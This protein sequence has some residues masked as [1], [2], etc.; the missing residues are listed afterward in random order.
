MIVKNESKF[1]RRCLDSYR[2]IADEI[3]IVDTGSTDNTKEIAHEYTNKVYDYKWDDD[4]SH[5]RNFAFSKATG[6]YIFSADADEVLDADNLVLFKQLKSV[7]LPEIDIVQMKYVNF[8]NG[9]SVYNSKKE[10]RPKLFKRLRT[11]QWISPIHET[12]RLT[13]VVFDSDIEILHMPERSHSKRDFHTFVKA[14]EKG[15]TLENYVVTMFCKELWSTG[16]NED[17]TALLP[18]FEK[19]MTSYTDESCFK[20]VNCILARMYR[21]AGRKDDFFKVTLKQI[22]D[23]PPAEICLELGNYYFNM[24]D[25]EEAVLWFI[26]ASSETGPILDVHAGGDSPLLKLSECYE[27][28]SQL[29]E[30]SGEKELSKNYMTMSSEYK[31]QAESWTLPEEI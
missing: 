9:N 7:L 26:N 2:P 16:D 5:A 3:I 1:L 29:A 11:F 14:L 31:S 17:Y 23:N 8:D 13:P 6:D 4:F 15:E 20:E 18:T 25:F 12:V 27:K 10:L 30:H 21:L 28:L 22:A 24:G 19:Y